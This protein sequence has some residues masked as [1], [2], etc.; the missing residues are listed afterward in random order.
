MRKLS[1]GNIFARLPGAKD[2]EVFQ[3]L[4]ANK[5][6]TIE[7]IITRGQTTD[8][9]SDARDEW[10]IVLK[11]AGSVRFRESRRLVKLKAGDYL[12][13]PGNTVHRVAWTA[14]RQQTL[15]LAVKM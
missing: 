14:P 3:T 4:L 5:K 10:V 12:F 2:K 13:I 9:L 8:W 7:R 1:R 6:V 15:W 11:G